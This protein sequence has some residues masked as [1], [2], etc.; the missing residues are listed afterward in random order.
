MYSR[1]NIPLNNSEEELQSCFNELRLLKTDSRDVHLSSL[2]TIIRNSTGQL[3]C[4]VKR[5]SVH[6]VLGICRRISAHVGLD[7]KESTDK[8]C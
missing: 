3:H 6:V 5:I 8:S 4:L 7:I 2:Q 1:Q